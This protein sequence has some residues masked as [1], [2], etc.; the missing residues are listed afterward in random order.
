MPQGIET[1]L[2]SFNVFLNYAYCVQIIDFYSYF[3][4]GKVKLKNKNQNF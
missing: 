2:T 3:Y 1:I 4:C